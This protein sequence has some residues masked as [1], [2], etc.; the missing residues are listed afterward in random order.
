MVV[1]G[2]RHREGVS[3]YPAGRSGE[4]LCPSPENLWFSYMKMVHSGT[5]LH[6]VFDIKGLFIYKF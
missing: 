5:F 3:P 2:V 1:R 6:P 4:G